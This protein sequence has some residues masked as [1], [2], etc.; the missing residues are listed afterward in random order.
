[1]NDRLKKYREEITARMVEALKDGTA[2]W[3][4]P[5][6]SGGCDRSP[7][8]AISGRHYNG[9]NALILLNIG[10]HLDNGA[11]PRWLTFRQAVGKGWNIRKGEHGTAI[12]FWKP[13]PV[14]VK[15]KDGKPMLD[16]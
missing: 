9:A 3:Q 13:L 14:E 10:F 15:G 11:D 4:Q 6:V 7:I 2:P 8:N 5:W 1:M 12:S 16:E